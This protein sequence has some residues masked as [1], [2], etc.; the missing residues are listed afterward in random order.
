[1]PR[2][3]IWIRR[4]APPYHP[5]MR[6][7]E[8]MKGPGRSP[9]P[10]SCSSGCAGSPYAVIGSSMGISAHKLMRMY[11]PCSENPARRMTR[12]ISAHGLSRIIKYKR[13]ASP[14]RPTRV[15]HVWARF[16]VASPALWKTRSSRAK[17]RQARPATIRKLAQGLGVPPSELLLSEHSAEGA[18]ES[19]NTQATATT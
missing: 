2:A 17:V 3:R 1:V 16:Q 8:I 9:R 12:T 19:E 6:F 4:L 14:Q 11:S 7:P 10:S 15:Q 18:T 13:C 5:E